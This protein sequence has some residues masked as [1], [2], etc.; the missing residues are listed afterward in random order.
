MTPTRLMP[1]GHTQAPL[2][3]KQAIKP[4]VPICIAGMP[5][6]GMPLV[7]R[8]LGGI[9]VDF[10]PIGEEPPGHDAAGRFSQLNEQI[11]QAVGAD[12]SSPPRGRDWIHFADVAQLRQQAA[13]TAEA[14]ALAE[15]WG[16][17]DP[18]NSLTLPFWRELFGD[19]RVLVCVRDPREVAGSLAG[20]GVAP[21]QVVRLWEEYYATLLELAGESCVVT[22]YDAYRSDPRPELCRLARGFGLDAS[23]VAI[24]WV[25][26]ANDSPAPVANSSTRE[27]A[28]SVQELYERLL[29]AARST[30][31][32]EEVRSEVGLDKEE[33]PDTLAAQRCELEHLRLELSRAR[34]EVDA[35]RVQLQVRVGEP[36]ELR[37]IVANLEE[38]LAERDEELEERRKALDA[39]H[40][41]RREMDAWRRE[42]EETLTTG[43]EALR[44]ELDWMRSTRLWRTGQR[45]WA[46]KDH[47]RKIG[48]RGSL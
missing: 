46:F 4:L 6:S 32:V 34:A 44:I 24:S 22:H 35:L 47:L 3:G 8:L 13:A 14:L 23:R 17:S 48:R 40:A 19:V 41:W 25:D 45:Y 36:I 39:G 33:L 26:R 21:Q 30:P 2:D 9:G 37:E 28:P 29:D 43:I 10:G 1:F 20:Q 16:W 27:L 7:C 31:R 42:T 11:L 5:Y 38:L 18:R 15:P 12:W